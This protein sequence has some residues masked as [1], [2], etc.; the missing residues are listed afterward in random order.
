MHMLCET[1]AV[2]IAMRWNGKLLFLALAAGFVLGMTKSD[3]KAAKCKDRGCGDYNVKQ[4]CQCDKVR[5]IAQLLCH[6]CEFT[7]VDTL[8]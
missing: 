7:T 5:R 4:A 6:L 2:R 8:D 3:A 1:S